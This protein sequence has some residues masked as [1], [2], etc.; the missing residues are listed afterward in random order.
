MPYRMTQ[1]SLQEKE[2]TDYTEQTIE[3]LPPLKEATGYP[4]IFPRDLFKS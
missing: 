1:S 2:L 3:G 4:T